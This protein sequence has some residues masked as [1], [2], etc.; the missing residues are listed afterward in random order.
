MPMKNLLKLLL[1]IPILALAQELPDEAW[2]C[3]SNGGSY[4]GLTTPYSS[5]ESG[6]RSLGKG[7]K[8]IF[9]PAKG[10]KLLYSKEFSTESCRVRGDYYSCRKDSFDGS[11]VDIFL[12]EPISRRFAMS[13]SR[14]LQIINSTSA[15]SWLGFCSKI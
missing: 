2:L 4:T 3:I 1:L 14:I 7:Q 13:S 9:N 10:F 11:Q 8:W 5:V 6:S 12:F 15:N